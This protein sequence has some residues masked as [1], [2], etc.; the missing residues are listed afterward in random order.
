MM[1]QGKRIRKDDLRILKAPIKD[2]NQKEKQRLKL[3]L[4]KWDINMEIV[5]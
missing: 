4:L 1:Y 2:L 5:E 3:I